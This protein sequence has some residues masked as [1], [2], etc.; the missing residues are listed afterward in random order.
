[1]KNHGSRRD[2]FLSFFVC[3]IILCSILATP[4]YAV[5]E[6]LWVQSDLMREGLQGTIQESRTASYMEDEK[7]PYIT[8]IA[9]YDR[10]GYFVTLTTLTQRDP[11]EP[12]LKTVR[13]YTP[14]ID[15]QR[16]IETTS[17]IDDQPLSQAFLTE[18]WEEH[19]FI[20]MSLDP[21]SGD[22]NQE[23]SELYDTDLRLIAKEYFRRRKPEVVEYSHYLGSEPFALDPEKIGISQVIKIPYEVITT[24]NLVELD[25]LEIPSNIEILMEMS[26]DLLGNEIESYHQTQYG[27]EKI[28]TQYNYY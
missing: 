28:I 23:Y 12:L 25:M 22:I 10:E 2:L 9:E 16:S 14:F 21:K 7:E 3:L 26:V 18:Q 1:M 8:R 27:V 4:L 11:S 15:N 13:Q 20:R 6:N 17:F 5:E 19:R 24:I